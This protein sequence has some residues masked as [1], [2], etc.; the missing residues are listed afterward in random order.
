MQRF[1]DEAELLNFRG[2]DYGWL[3]SA[4]LESGFDFYFDDEPDLSGDCSHADVISDYA[5][6]AGSIGTLQG[7]PFDRAA[8]VEWC[9]RLRLQAAQ[10][11]CARLLAGY[12]AVA[13]RAPHRR[14]HPL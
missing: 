1:D 10:P 7:F 4:A 3:S 2:E 11:L 9:W 13:L 8:E 5:E 6:C 14:L 12:A